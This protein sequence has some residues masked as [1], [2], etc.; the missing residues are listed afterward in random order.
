MAELSLQQQ[1]ITDHMTP[2]FSLFEVLE[3][4]FN[5]S[6]ELQKGLELE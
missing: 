2:F 6:W 5:P 4:P 3:S 1:C